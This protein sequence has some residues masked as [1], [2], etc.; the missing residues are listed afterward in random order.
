MKQIHSRDNPHFKTLLKLAASAKERRVS[1]V[2]LLDGDHLVKACR[3]AGMTIHLLAI[4][5][6]AVGDRSKQ[7]LFDSTTAHERFILSD[8]LLNIVSPVSTASGLVAVAPIPKPADFPQVA[9]TCLMLESIQDA[10]N[11][12]S[13]LRTAAAAG[14]GHAALSAGCVSAWGPKVLR[15]GMGAHFQLSI[16]ERA[17]L[18]AL[19]SRYHGT[20]AAAQPRGLVDLYQADLSGPVAWL[21]G[22]EGNGL[23]PELSECSSIA[24]RIPMAGPTESLNV[25]S[26]AAICL[27]EQVRQQKYGKF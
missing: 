19:A 16:H 23:S 20:I 4:A 1:Q 8:Q 14:V 2:M 10:G 22:N 18:I 12:G 27:F 21:F 11:L 3:D 17:D 5:E 15:A 7:Q 13:I 9:Q 26:A 6:S 24:I 25:G